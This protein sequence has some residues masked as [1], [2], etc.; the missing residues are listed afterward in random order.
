MVEVAVS[1]WF[2][3]VSLLL[4]SHRQCFLH[5]AGG[6]SIWMKS[7]ASISGTTCL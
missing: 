5:L 7:V 3:C 2:A 6:T 4:S 1:L